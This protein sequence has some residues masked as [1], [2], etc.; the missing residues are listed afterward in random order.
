[1]KAAFR[2]RGLPLSLSLA[3][4]NDHPASHTKLSHCLRSLASCYSPKQVLHHQWQRQLHDPAVQHGR[5]SM[6]ASSRLHQAAEICG[7]K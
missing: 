7:S 2:T 3:T 1:M 6:R 5:M 4:I